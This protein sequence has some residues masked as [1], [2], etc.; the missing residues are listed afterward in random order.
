MLV[1]A[2]CQRRCQHG[3]TCDRIGTDDDGDERISRTIDYVF[4]ARSFSIYGGI[5]DDG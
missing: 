4:L 5:Y 2:Q 3:R 1:E